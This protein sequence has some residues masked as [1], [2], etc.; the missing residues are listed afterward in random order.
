MD[1]K[2]YKYFLMRIHRSL[3]ISMCDGRRTSLVGI[4]GT[5]FSSYDL[6]CDYKDHT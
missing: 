1:I 2:T 4:S 3:C 6:V 5:Y